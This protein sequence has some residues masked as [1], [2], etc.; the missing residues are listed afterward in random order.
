VEWRGGRLCACVAREPLN[1]RFQDAAELEFIDVAVNAVG[2]ADISLIGEFADG[3]AGNLRLD[4]GD[5]DQR[6]ELGAEQK[7]PAY[8]PVI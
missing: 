5:L 7:F 4:G 1:G 3:P 6:L 8:P 2:C